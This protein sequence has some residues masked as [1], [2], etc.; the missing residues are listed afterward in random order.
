[1]NSP[2]DGIQRSLGRLEGTLKEFGKKLEAIEAGQERIWKSIDDMKKEKAEE[3]KDIQIKIAKIE[4][5]KVG[6]RDLSGAVKTGLGII[7]T[8]LAFLTILEA[9][10]GGI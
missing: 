9:I 5:Q 8:A 3:I 6:W 2:D 4:N 1:M 10:K 7:S